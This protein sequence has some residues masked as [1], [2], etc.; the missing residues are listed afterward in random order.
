[1]ASTTMNHI[2]PLMIKDIIFHLYCYTNYLRHGILVQLSNSPQV[3]IL[4]FQKVHSTTMEYHLITIQVEMGINSLPITDWTFHSPTKIPKNNLKTGN[5]SG[6][7]VYIIFMTI[8]TF[9]LSLSKWLTA[10]LVHP[11]HIR[12]ICT[13]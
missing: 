12:C 5:P 2:Q 1:M 4:Q 6:I 9:F 10:I 11:K 7:L 3:D 13:V 8:R